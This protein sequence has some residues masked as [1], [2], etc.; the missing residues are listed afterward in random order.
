MLSIGAAPVG[1][2]RGAVRLQTPGFAADGRGNFVV[3]WQGDGVRGGGRGIVARRFDHH[4][5]ARGRAFHV[6]TFTAGM[7]NDAAVA[8]ERS[9]R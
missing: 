5:A 9:F 7:Q 4:G 1:V 2:A 6:N 8:M 3:V